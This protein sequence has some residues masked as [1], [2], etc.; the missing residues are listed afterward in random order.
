MAA[1]VSAASVRDSVADVTVKV[2]RSHW[3]LSGIVE[4]AVLPE[5]RSEAIESLDMLSEAIAKLR[6]LAVYLSHQEPPR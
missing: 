1:E 3:L 2:S 5:I 6:D 4:Q